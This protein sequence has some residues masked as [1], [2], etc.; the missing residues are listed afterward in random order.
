MDCSAICEL[1]EHM[2]LIIFVSSAYSIKLNC[3]HAMWMSF[4]WMIQNKGP[5]IEPRGTPALE[6]QMSDTVPLKSQTVV[7]VISN[8]ETTLKQSQKSRINSTWSK[9]W[10]DLEC[11]MPWINK[12]H[13]Q[14]N[15]YKRIRSTNSTAVSSVE[16]IF[17]KSYWPSIK[18]FA[19]KSNSKP[20]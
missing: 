17:R 18:D 4:T 20:E 1:N 9:E 11:K 16:W 3:L 14:R 10:R 5:G 8:F 7:Y 13:W 2:G 12:K 19:L 15:L 6:V